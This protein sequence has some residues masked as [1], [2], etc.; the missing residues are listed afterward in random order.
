MRKV[1]FLALVLALCFAA[2]ATAEE[3]PRVGIS[4][5]YS[6]DGWVAAAACSAETTAEALGLNYMLK[7]AATEAEQAEDLELMVEQDFEY[8]L[9]FPVGDEVEAAAQRVLDAGVTL[10]SF[11]GVPGEVEPDYSLVFDDAQAGALGAEYIAEKLG[12]EGSVALVT[13]ASDAGSERRAAACRDALAE[14]YP[15]IEIIGEY[16]AE[17]ADAETG[18]A[19]MREI[20][21][22]NPALDGVYSCDGGLFTGLLRAV[23]AQGRLGGDGVKVLTGCGGSREVFRR[24]NEYGDRISLAVQTAS[25]CMLGELV[26]MCDGLIR[27]ESCEATTIIPPETLECA[28]TAGWMLQNGVAENVPF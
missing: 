18:D 24:M 12:G 10:L 27:G 23:E 3:Q 9:L 7:S 6:P 13:L 11:G 2:A 1:L 25:P 20:L 15:G 19:L 22:E 16:A 17:R 21:A 8:I 28:D 4:C 26:R 14:K 5:P